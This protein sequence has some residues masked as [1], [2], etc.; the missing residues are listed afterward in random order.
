MSKRLSMKYLWQLYAETKAEPLYA[1]D[2]L[3][4]VE[5]KLKATRFTTKEE[6]PAK[7]KRRPIAP[8]DK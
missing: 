7:S 6:L 8:K 3:Y 4:F 2:F 5:E 1:K